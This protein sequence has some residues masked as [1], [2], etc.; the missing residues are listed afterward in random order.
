M[1]LYVKQNQNL[2]AI[3]YYTLLFI[4]ALYNTSLNMSKKCSFV[5]SCDLML[6]KV[7]TSIAAVP[8]HFHD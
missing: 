2:V 5:N 3:D 6:R 4:L 7:M 1:K 8:P